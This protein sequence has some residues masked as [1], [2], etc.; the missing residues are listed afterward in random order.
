MPLVFVCESLDEIGMMIPG[1]G[2]R[3]NLKPFPQPAKRVASAWGGYSLA[4]VPVIIEEE[5]EFYPIGVGVGAMALGLRVHRN[6]R[7]TDSRRHHLWTA[8]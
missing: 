8:A 5:V 4:R 1:G 6:V 3:L 2:H 7:T